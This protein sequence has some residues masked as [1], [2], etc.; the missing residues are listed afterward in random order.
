M[1]VVQMGGDTNKKPVQGSSCGG[2]AGVE[3][4]VK[5]YDINDNDERLLKDGTEL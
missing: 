1:Q 4:I 2:K 3:G 5:S